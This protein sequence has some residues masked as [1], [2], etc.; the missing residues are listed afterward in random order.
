MSTLAQ[1]ISE[2]QAFLASRRAE[3]PGVALILGSGFAELAEAVDARCVLAYKDIPHFAAT[4]VAGHAGRLL[5]GRWRGVEVA[6]FEGRSHFY[7]GLALQQVA[8][9]SYIAKELGAQALIVTNAAG[10]INA[11]YEPGD[12]MLVTDHINLI[13]DSPLRGPQD[14]GVGIRFP[15]MRNA[16]DPALLNAARRAAAACK[17][18]LR[19]GVYAA[20]AGPMYET[21]AELRMLQTLG[22]D[23]VGMSTVPEVIAARHAGLRVLA[24]SVISNRASPSPDATVASGIVA[25]EAPAAHRGHDVD[26]EDVQATVKRSAHKARAVIEGVLDELAG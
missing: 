24:L 1:R 9:P 22:A 11:D 13:G 3:R 26:H 4:S 17:V 8:Y 10:A 12:V 6:M 19:E 16:Y 21:E 2:T 14:G 5:L 7:E 20:V 15:S 23:A 18:R 25:D